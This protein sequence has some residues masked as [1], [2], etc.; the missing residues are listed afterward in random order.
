MGGD[1]EE[2]TPDLGSCRRETSSIVADIFTLITDK[3]ESQSPIFDDSNARDRYV[4]LTALIGCMKSLDN[5]SVNMAIAYGRNGL[6][7]TPPFIKKKREN[8]M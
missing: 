3:V 5:I 4:I 2:Y 8:F 7:L 1:A 6:C